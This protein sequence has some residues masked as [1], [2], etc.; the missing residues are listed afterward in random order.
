[1]M[2]PPGISKWSCAIGKPRKTFN[3]IISTTNMTLIICAR[4]IAT[5]KNTSVHVS[6]QFYGLHIWKTYFKYNSTLQNGKEDHAVFALFNSGKEVSVQWQVFLSPF[7]SL[8]QEFSVLKG[9]GP[10]GVTNFIWSHTLPT[11]PN[12]WNR[13]YYTSGPGTR[14]GLIF[15]FRHPSVSWTDWLIYVIN[16]GS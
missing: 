6:K 11:C 10:F 5:G 12:A 4:H 14:T 13:E 1:M 15:L 9:L 2:V 8:S 16:I 7:A 3:V